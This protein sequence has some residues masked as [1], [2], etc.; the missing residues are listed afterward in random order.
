MKKLL[1][2]DEVLL[3]QV[4]ATERFL[5]LQT[6]RFF[7]I[8]ILF[9]VIANGYFGWMMSK[10]ILSILMM[11]LL[12]GFI[13]FSVLRIAILTMISLPL[14]NSS[15][16]SVSST[17]LTLTINKIK[18]VISFASV[19]RFIFVCCIAVSVAFPMVSLINF[20]ETERLNLLK[21]NEVFQLTIEN[22][23]GMEFVP[24]VLREELMTTNY[25]FFVFRS[26]L[27][28]SF[29]ILQLFLIVIC[30]FVPFG[31]LFYIRSKPSFK[32]AENASKSAFMSIEADYLM[33]MEECQWIVE[34]DFP[35]HAI[36]L[37]DLSPYLDPPFNS[38]LKNAKTRQM[39]TEAEFQQKIRLM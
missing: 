11:S 19:V 34:K 13:H 9:S 21:R 10:S 12:V 26:W 1:G 16:D 35:S 25:P 36:S 17:K 6:S 30:F 4:N 22:A 32:Y 2:L 5:F 18:S 29:T 23:G 33:T 7:L 3:D 8:T 20:R 27:G 28:S 38:K 24:N 15:S 31:L 37:K 14:V 39:G